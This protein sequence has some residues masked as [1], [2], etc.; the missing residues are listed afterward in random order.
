M[1]ILVCYDGSADARGAIDRTA[2]LFPAAEARILVVWDMASKILAGA[3]LGMGPYAGM[4]DLAGLDD[5]AEQRAHELASEGVELAKQAGLA[6]ISDTARLLGTTA[7]TILDAAETLDADAIVV[8][9]EEE[10]ECVRCFWEAF[11]TRYFS[12]P[13]GRSS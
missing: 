12:I 8:G 7:E 13:T 3:G 9:P 4:V 5:A 1:R 2:T 6:A 11:R 10:V